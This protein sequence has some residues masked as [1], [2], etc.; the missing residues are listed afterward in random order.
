MPP[1]SAAERAARLGNVAA[2]FIDL[3]RR[4]RPAEA[5]PATAEDDAPEATEVSHAPAN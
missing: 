1:I 2:I 3:G 5:T 4:A